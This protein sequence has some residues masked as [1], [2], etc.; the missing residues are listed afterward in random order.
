MF[1]LARRRLHVQL[2]SICLVLLLMCEHVWICVHECVCARESGVLS[3]KACQSEDNFVEGVLGL[4]FSSNVGFRGGTQIA[5]VLK[6]VLLPAELSFW[7]GPAVTSRDNRSS[8]RTGH[9]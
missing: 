4:S 9:R 5:R 1:W 3:R 7:P 8:N 2:V 6:Q